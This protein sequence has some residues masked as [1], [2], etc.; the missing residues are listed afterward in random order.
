[1]FSSLAIHATRNIYAVSGGV[2]AITA[3]VTAAGF[4]L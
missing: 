2:C 3:T 1:M 4:S